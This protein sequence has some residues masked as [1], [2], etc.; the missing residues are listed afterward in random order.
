MNRNKTD[1]K[2]DTAAS[3]FFFAISWK[4]CYNFIPYRSVIADYIF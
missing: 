1:A 3:V 4:M 2:D